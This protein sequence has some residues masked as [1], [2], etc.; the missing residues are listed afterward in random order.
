[1]CFVG[2][3]WSPASNGNNEWVRIT[4]PDVYQLYSVTTRGG[5]MPSAWITGYT[6][7]YGLSASHQTYIKDDAGNTIQYIANTDVSSLIANLVPVGLIS[8][9][10]TLH[11]TGYS[12]RIAV[13]LDI[14]GCSVLGILPSFYFFKPSSFHS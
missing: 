2:G 12:T 3:A 9:V 4:T 6:L 13:R 14:K 8:K 7:E 10:T 11:P 5:G 1:M